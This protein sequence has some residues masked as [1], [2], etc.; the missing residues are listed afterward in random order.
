MKKVYFILMALLMPQISFANA[1]NE[2]DFVPELVFSSSYGQLQY[3]FSKSK[4]YI[5]QIAHQN[6]QE[7]NF[8]AGGLAVATLEM[9]V[10]LDSVSSYK[11]K[12]NVCVAP[13]KVYVFIGFQDPTIYVANHLKQGECRFNVTLR[14]EQAHMQINKKALEHYLPEF[15]AAINDIIKTIK[16]LNI[17][18]LADSKQANEYLNYQYYTKIKEYVEKFN[19]ILRQEQRRLDNKENYAFESTLCG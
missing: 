10:K 3:D 15:K 12:N 4:E 5:S 18:N 16:P 13:K 1:C 9:S 19:E 14:H 8:V 2:V 17:G 7:E 6:G 11:Q